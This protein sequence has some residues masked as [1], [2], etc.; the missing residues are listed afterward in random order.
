[1]RWAFGHVPVIGDYFDAVTDIFDPS[2]C[3]CP[4]VD[5]RGV[6]VVVYPSSVTRPWI[7]HNARSTC[8]CCPCCYEM[9]VTI[10]IFRPVIVGH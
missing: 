8:G 4:R 3:P 9:T 7:S 6:R 1:M 2:G 5:S 10:G